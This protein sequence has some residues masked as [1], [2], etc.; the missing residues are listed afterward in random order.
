[1]GADNAG[2][3]DMGDSILLAESVARSRISGI[4]ERVIQDTRTRDPLK[5]RGRRTLDGRFCKSHCA[6]RRAWGRL[7]Y[8]SSVFGLD[9]LVDEDLPDLSNFRFKLD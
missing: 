6:D 1:M 7:S 3:V 9:V 5:V 8:G 4:R 2:G